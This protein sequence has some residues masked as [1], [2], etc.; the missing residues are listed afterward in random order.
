MQKNIL[1]AKTV[2]ALQYK[3]FP[4]TIEMDTP[5]YFI[6]YAMKIT[7]VEAASIIN[8]KNKHIGFVTMDDIINKSNEAAF[9]D[10]TIY[11]VDIMHPADIAVGPEDTISQALKLMRRC[12]LEWLPV[13]DPNT[14]KFTGLIYKEDLLKEDKRPVIYQNGIPIKEHVNFN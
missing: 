13:I 6:C 5:L 9:D 11:A 12:R 3:H 8:H 14:R 4:L 2:E 10:D 7:Q 1:P